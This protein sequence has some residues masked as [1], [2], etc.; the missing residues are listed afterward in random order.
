VREGKAER[1]SVVIR[2][3]RR[4]ILLAG[5]L[6][7][8][9]AGIA[10]WQWSPLASSGPPRSSSGPAPSGS[11]TSRSGTP[12]PAAAASRPAASRPAPNWPSYL[13]DPAHRMLLGAFTDLAGQPSTEAAV[14][15]REAAMG[16]R[17]DLE[18]TYYNWDDVFPD[19]G[20]AAIVAHGRTPMMTWYGPG[21]DSSDHRT[22]A[23]INNGHDD[24]W[25][26][27][28]A[29]AIRDFGH[30][31]YLRVMPE[32]NGDWYLGFSANPTAFIAAWQR[33]HRLFA[34][35]GATNVTWVWCPNI[36][37]YDWDRYYPGNAYVDIIGVD[38]FSNT[39]Y[40]WQTFEHMFDPFLAHYAGRKPLMIGETATNSGAG[41]PA[42][43]I[44][45]AATFVSGMR[46]YLKDVAGPRYGVTGVCWFDTNAIDS[47]DWRVNQTPA[48]WQAWLS[49]A[50]DPYFGGHGG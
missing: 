35:A 11:E 7:L 32:M 28:Q 25:I 42:A 8:A 31:I 29:G 44:G 48:A 6:I 14:E 1:G 45:S 38:G 12:T 13:P 30:R 22:L 39:R 49:L 37:P 46:T 16:R 18:V 21:K 3:T 36:T 17:Y 5:A 50:R 9:V 34:Q 33:I 47:H 10:V 26:L 2:G 23:E 41:D 43:G 24:G 27:Q 20:E 40:R 15:Q 19:F 4:W